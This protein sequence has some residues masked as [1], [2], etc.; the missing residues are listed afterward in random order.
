MKKCVVIKEM[1]EP[2]LHSKFQKLKI[3]IRLTKRTNPYFG[4]VRF[5]PKYNSAFFLNEI[6]KAHWSSDNDL[7]G[8]TKIF[9][10]KCIDFQEFRY[11]NTNKSALKLPKELEE[12]RKI[13]KSH[14]Q[15]ISQNILIQWRDYLIGEI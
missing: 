15:S 2:R 11:L 14:H 1:Q 12:I 3:P 5:Y 13:Q 4:V 8:M 6:I 7:V 9:T 10:R